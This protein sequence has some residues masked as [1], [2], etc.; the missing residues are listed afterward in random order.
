MRL[1]ES[2]DKVFFHSFI[3]LNYITDCVLCT[4]HC[5]NAIR[6][7]TRTLYAVMLSQCV[8]LES[9]YGFH[10]VHCV[11][12][13]WTTD[14]CKVSKL[15]AFVKNMYA[16]PGPSAHWENVLPEGVGGEHWGGGLKYHLLL[17]KLSQK[18][19][20]KELKADS[21]KAEENKDRWTIERG[22]W[23]RNYQWRCDWT[24]HWWLPRRG[25]WKCRDNRGDD[26]SGKR[27]KKK[28]K[29]KWLSLIP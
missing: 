25:R 16:G 28:K 21:K 19:N 1:C 24:R 10:W 8:G 4:S 11:C 7:K 5:E 18:K 9:G 6:K 12:H 23:S 20:A 13:L 17:I 27:L 15:R 26:G 2:Y 14:P 29:K 22:N 3:H